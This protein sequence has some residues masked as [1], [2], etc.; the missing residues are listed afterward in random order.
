MIKPPRLNHRPRLRKPRTV[1]VVIRGCIH[2]VSPAQARELQKL[3]SS[4]MA[5]DWKLNRVD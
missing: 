2:L 1:E 5:S 4:A 3:K